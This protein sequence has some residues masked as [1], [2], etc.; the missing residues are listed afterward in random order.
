[1]LETSVR[2]FGSCAV[3]LSRVIAVSPSRLVLE[4]GIVVHG[5]RRDEFCDL[6]A[7]FPEAEDQRAPS[8]STESTA[9]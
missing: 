6:V 8:S 2:R 3:D 1:M 7:A 4:T 5:E 9:G